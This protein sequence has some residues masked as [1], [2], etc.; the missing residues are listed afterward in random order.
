MKKIILL[1]TAAV[2]LCTVLF[3]QTNFS[4]TGTVPGRISGNIQLILDPTFLGKNPQT[5]TAPIINGRFE[6]KAKIERNCFIQLNHSTLKLP[7]Y[8][9]PGFDLTLE[10]PEGTTSFSNVLS[11]KGAAENN[12]LQLFFA[13]FGNDFND[14]IN[15]AQMLVT[16]IDAFES[17]LFTKKKSHHE[18]VKTDPNK[19]TFSPLFNTFIESE[20]NYHYWRELFAFPIVNANRDSKIMTVV[21]LP[22]VML[23]SLEA[24]KIN[25]DAA[26]MSNSYRDFIKYFIIYNS[27]KA[28]GFNKFTDGANSAERKSA[29]AKEKLSGNV[30]I[31]WLARYTIE[32]CGSIGGMMAKKLLATLKEVDTGK[33]SYTIAESLCNT[34][35]MSETQ[36]TATK[37]SGT[38]VNESDAGLLDHN[39]K[40]VSLSS[41]KGKVVYIDFWASWCGPCRMMMPHSKQMH[42]QLT[43]KQK[44]QIVFLYISIDADTASWR[45]AI[46]DLHME[47]TQYI[48]PGNWKSAACK[49][50]QIN[51]IPRY[52]IM[53][54]KG[55][56]VEMNAKRPADPEVL[57][58]L[59]RLAEEN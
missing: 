32:E 8:A 57:Q 14:S 45:K 35:T 12:F 56:M 33:A 48:S 44:K 9:E 7:M 10:I 49:Y 37:P 42:A 28:N 22:Q 3:A 15:E 34:R 23:E 17:S 53:N 58:Q 29:V 59:I 47:G 5:I 51:S 40:P 19:S 13:R 55:E 54:K 4:I 18:F 43:A 26:L 24:S 27:S 50:F 11:G 30:Y 1:F 16:T 52:M 21:P 38:P 39:M 20:I 2:M 41:L 31:Y 36:A 25:N 46:R 6:L